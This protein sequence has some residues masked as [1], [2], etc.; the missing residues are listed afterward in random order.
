MIPGRILNEYEGWINCIR[1]R[2]F[3]LSG[4]V[5][6][7]NFLTELLSTFQ[8]LLTVLVL[9]KRHDACTSLLHTKTDL[10]SFPFSLSLPHLI[11]HILNKSSG[12]LTISGYRNCSSAYQWRS[13]SAVRHSTARTNIDTRTPSTKALMV[14]TTSARLIVCQSF[15]TG[16]FVLP[17]VL[18]RRRFIKTPV[19]IFW[20]LRKRK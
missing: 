4:F 2:I 9:R 6:S 5:P 3:A 17:S 18:S 8:K 10:G 14:A 15:G 11:V 7:V 16:G 13:K 19:G 20:R 1:I 12:C